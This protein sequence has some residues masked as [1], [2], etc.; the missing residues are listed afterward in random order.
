MKAI[1][2]SSCHYFRQVKASMITV[3]EL[4]DA[5]EAGDKL[6]DVV[7]GVDCEI[8]ERGFPPKRSAV[9]APRLHWS[10]EVTLTVNGKCGEIEGR[11]LFAGPTDEI[12]CRILDCVISGK[13]ESFPINVPVVGAIRFREYDCPAILLA[14]ESLYCKIVVL[15]KR[16]EFLFETDDQIGFVCV[17]PNS[18]LLE[19][20]INV[21]L[22]TNAPDSGRL[23]DWVEED[24]PIQLI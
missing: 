4:G 1:F 12:Q 15:D 20:D 13:N 8:N 11:M 2:V 17:G 16:R 24:E 5:V 21:D 9:T 22:V 14:N 10:R 18:Q 6:C 19:L 3:F 23:L 7:N